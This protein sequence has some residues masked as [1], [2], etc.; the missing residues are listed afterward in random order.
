MSGGGLL[1]IIFESNVSYWANEPPYKEYHYNCQEDKAQLL[2][3]RG[4]PPVIRSSFHHWHCASEFSRGP[5]DVR[6]RAPS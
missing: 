5:A 4:V 6:G 1:M 3:A 2:V